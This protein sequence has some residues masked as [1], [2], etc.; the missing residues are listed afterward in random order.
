MAIKREWI[1][2][3]QRVLAGD[4]EVLRCPER[5]D[6]LLLVDW[7]PAE[8]YARGEYWVRCPGCGA[9]TYILKTVGSEDAEG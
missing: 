2:V 7:L 3:A 9:E 6:D 4:T 8:K 5:D 1:E